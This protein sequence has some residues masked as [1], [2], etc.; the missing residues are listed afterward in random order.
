MEE[1]GEEGA[2]AGIGRWDRRPGSCCTSGRG[3]GSGGAVTGGDGEERRHDGTTGVAW[4][5]RG[6]GTGRAED[7]GLPGLIPK[8]QLLWRPPSPGPPSQLL[9]CSPSA[10]SGR[11]VILISNFL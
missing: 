6:S 4:S 5:H 1:K 10:E 9:S 11:K 8:W 3:G 2:E 7:W